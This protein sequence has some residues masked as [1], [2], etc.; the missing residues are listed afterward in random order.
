MTVQVTAH[1]ALAMTVQVTA[2]LALAMTNLSAGSARLN[3]VQ[4]L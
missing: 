4:N 2:H 1:L 3:L